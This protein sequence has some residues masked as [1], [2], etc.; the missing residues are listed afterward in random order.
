MHPQLWSG[1]YEN[2][3]TKAVAL[4]AEGQV[5]EDGAEVRISGFGKEEVSALSELQ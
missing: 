2:E 5:T 4:P 3:N 1:F